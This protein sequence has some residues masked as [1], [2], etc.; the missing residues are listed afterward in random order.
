MLARFGDLAGAAALWEGWLAEH[1]DTPEAR[2]WLGKLARERGDEAGAVE[3]FRAAFAGRP[4]LPGAQVLLGAALVNAGLADEARE[5]LERDIPA[6]AGNPNRSILLGHARMQSGDP[7]GARV[8]FERAVELAPGSVH[9]VYGLANAC[10]RLGDT[11]AAK[12]YRE[13]VDA[14]KDKNLELDR[15]RGM[16]Q[17]DDLPSLLPVV[18][19]WYAA[20][21]RIE[22]LERDPAAAERRWLRAVQFDPAQREAVGELERSWRRRGRD[23]DA[24][25]LVKAA[26]EALASRA[27]RPD[28]MAEE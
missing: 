25:R 15:A 16:Q 7:A 3:H 4:E 8:A 26:R 27:A 17:L 28:A 14:R 22:S 18:A 21:G 10:A 23:A 6:V 20:A 2:L 1:P 19:R 11:A 24:D 12:R 13:E 5:V 9:A